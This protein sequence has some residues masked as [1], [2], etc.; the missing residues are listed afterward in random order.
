MFWHHFR[1]SANLLLCHSWFTSETKN[2]NLTVAAKG[3]KLMQGRNMCLR[4]SVWFISSFDLALLVLFFSFLLLSFCLYQLH[5]YLLAAAKRRIG[6]ALK[7]ARAMLAIK[8]GKTATPLHPT[9]DLSDVRTTITEEPFLW[10]II[11]FHLS[12][13]NMCW[14]FI[15][16]VFFTQAPFSML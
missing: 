5:L 14:N 4:V 11:F 2:V 13:C 8:V 10:R 7:T 12:V 15:N 3:L 9:D 16:W 6:V 1:Y